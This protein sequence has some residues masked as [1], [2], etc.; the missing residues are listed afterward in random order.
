MAEST[1]TRTV[2]V[3]RARANPV[4]MKQHRASI[5]ALRRG[6]RPIP[7]DQF[8]REEHAQGADR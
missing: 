4:L 1:E 8:R 7:F 3:E 5:E 6:E 2:A